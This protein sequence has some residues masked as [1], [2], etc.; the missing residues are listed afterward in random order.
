MLVATDFCVSQLWT[1]ARWRDNM[2]KE[3]LSNMTSSRREAQFLSKK[4][5]LPRVLTGLL[6]L[7]ESSIS[8]L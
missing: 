2:D 1:A 8:P 7:S 4:E 6:R 3:G 5:K